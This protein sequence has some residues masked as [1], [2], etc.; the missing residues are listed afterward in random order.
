MEMENTKKQINQGDIFNQNPPPVNPTLNQKGNFLLI[1]GIIIL[2]LVVGA[3]GYFLYQKQVN[4]PVTIPQASQLT[5]SPTPGE[6]A[7][8]K[9]YTNTTWNYQFQ[10]PSTWIVE[11][12]DTE[13]VVI[14]S[15]DIEKSV[16][17]RITKFPTNYIRVSIVNRENITRSF[18]EEIKSV[19]T[20]S[21]QCSVGSECPS[22]PPLITKKT[23]ANSLE[24]YFLTTGVYNNELTIFSLPKDKNRYVLIDPRLA[25][26]SNIKLPEKISSTFKFTDQ[27]GFC[28]DSICQEV[29]C[30]A[31]GC[32]KPETPQSCPQDCQTSGYKFQP[33]S[34]F[35]KNGFTSGTYETEGYVV[36]RYTCPICPQGAQCKP[37]MKNNIVISEE[38]QTLETYSLSDKNLIIFTNNP[39]QFTLNRKYTFIIKVLDYKSTGDSIN[40]VELVS[41]EQSR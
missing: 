13:H 33:I 19:Y 5:P 10:Y 35:K 9:A 34:E 40:D 41:F 1:I 11:E 7:N 3:G 12:L 38:N 25:L 17:G 15:S 29:V 2:L 23:N 26:A 6:T 30:T 24:Y 4:K 22:S 21:P 16:D 14:T 28:G 36:K 27:A 32:P 18:D 39:N 8:W 20:E 31:I 37:C